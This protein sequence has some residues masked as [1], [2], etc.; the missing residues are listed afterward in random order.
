MRL[1]VGVI[2]HV[3]HG[4]TALVRAL[5]GMETD[6][7]AEEKRRGISIALG[8]A[9]LPIPGGTVDL[10]DMPGHERFVRTMV[11][12]ATGM[13]AALL[14]VAANEGIKPQTRE[15]LD[16]AALLGVWR[17]VVAI[18]KADLDPAAAVTAEAAA[19]SEVRRRGMTVVGSVLTSATTGQGIEDLRAALATAAGEALPPADDGFFLLPIDRAFSITGHGTVVTGTLRR[20]P[21][22]VSDEVALEPGGRRLRL[23]G[24]QVNGV[25]TSIAMPGQR[26]AANLRDVEPSQVPRGAALCSRGALLPATWLSVALEAVAEAPELSNGA[27]LTLLVGTAEIGVR[28]RL[29][30]RDVLAAGERCF[31]QLHGAAPVAIPARERFILRRPSPAQ[32]VA[33]GRVL[34]PGATR[35]RRLRPAAPPSADHLRLA[36][37]ADAEPAEILRMLVETAGTA[38]VGLARASQWAGVSAAR[39]TMLLAAAPVAILGG[40][41]AVTRSGLDEVV[42]AL[43]R[44][45]ERRPDGVSRERLPSLL[46]G[47]GEAVLE[48]ALAILGQR[49]T[50]RSSGGMVQ[51]RRPEQ[52]RDAAR[53]EAMA[54]AKLAESLRRA[55]LSPPDIGA[56]AP[57]KLSQRLVNRLIREGL[58]VRTVDVVQK[59]DVV[60][61]RDAVETAKARLRPHLSR[62]PGLLVGE[63]GAVLG[64]SRKFSVPLLEHLDA[65]RFTRRIKDRR[66]IAAPAAEGLPPR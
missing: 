5:S 33:G 11:S 37:L 14:V 35:L 27:Q 43:P 51:L 8:F 52:E 16:I 54:A 7:L 26:V 56:L 57:D 2:G 39:A 17:V 22:A 63:A 65:I 42:R 32:T 20:G 3:D 61:H 59:R 9:F 31:A 40:G 10:I 4:K 36:A 38:G 13:A 64:I 62:P 55:G 18:S 49:G 44:A 15:H 19:T 45:L 41:T 25:R 66:I 1:V 24:L 58:A 6:R 30:D 12:G 23:R 47:V 50:V 60:F 46:P 48:A 29:L 53:D 28:L 21:L 34:D